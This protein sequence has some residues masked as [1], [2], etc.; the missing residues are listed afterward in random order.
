M[1]SETS[2]WGAGAGVDATGMGK[3]YMYVVELANLE[4]EA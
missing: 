2:K 1:V 3:V 4:E